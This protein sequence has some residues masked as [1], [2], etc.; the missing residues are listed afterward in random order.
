M[1]APSSW[2]TGPLAY[3]ELYTKPA[4]T[5]H[6]GHGMYPISPLRDTSGN[7]RGAI[8]ALTNIRQSCM[9]VP[10]FPKPNAAD[11]QEFHQT[12][13]YENVLDKAKSFV[14]NNHLNMYSYQTIY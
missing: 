2:P 11:A 12:W 7:L 1:P 3:I 4:P 8:I 10:V 14:I 6:Q 5:A 13:T 9:L